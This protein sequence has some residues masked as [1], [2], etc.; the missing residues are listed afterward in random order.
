MGKSGLFPWS[1]QDTSGLCE[2][3]KHNSR[4]ILMKLH[5]FEERRRLGD[6]RV[7]APVEG[8]PAYYARSAHNRRCKD[9]FP[10]ALTEED[11]ECA[12]MMLVTAS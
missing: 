8:L 6:R 3:G 7:R 10:D 5:E 11:V 12:S 2:S 1:A 4:G 9:M